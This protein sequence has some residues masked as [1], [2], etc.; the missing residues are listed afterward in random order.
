MRNAPDHDLCEGVLGEDMALMGQCPG[1]HVGECTNSSEL[2]SDTPTL[3]G[4]SGLVS[5]LKPRVQPDGLTGWL[6]M[7]L[8][9]NPRG[10]QPHDPTTII[11]SAAVLAAVGALG[12]WLPA[13]RASRIDPAEVLREVDSG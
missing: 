10:L 4:A 1:L 12:A 6:A 11:F 2:L 3:E 7:C 9:T 13:Y 5:T 8:R